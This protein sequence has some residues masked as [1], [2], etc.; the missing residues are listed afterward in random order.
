MSL[1]DEAKR[2]DQEILNTMQELEV[3]C[4]ALAVELNKANEN[5]RQQ[6]KTDASENADLQIAR[7]RQANANYAYSLASRN[8]E[9]LKKG[10]SA[11]YESDGVVKLGSTVD[12]K[13]LTDVPTVQK[14]NFIMRIMVHDAGNASRGF[15][16]EDST[17]GAAIMGRMAGDHVQVK[18]PHGTLEYL[19]ERML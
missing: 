18:A 13:L 11:D 10:L 7:E 3:T 2:I 19:I 17:V 4:K 16:A 5:V 8:Y 12:L 6:E 15:L 9:A 1:E 14:R